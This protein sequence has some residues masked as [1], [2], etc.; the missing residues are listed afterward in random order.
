MIRRQDILPL[1]LYYLGVSRVRN[2]FIRLQGRSVTRI[3]TFHDI[4]PEAFDNFQTNINFLKQKTNVIGFQ[5]YFE[6][7]L[8]KKKINVIITFDDG[9]KS[10]LTY[11]VPA[12]K[13]LGLP[14][15]FFVTTGFVGLSKEAESE[16]I[17]SKL[18]VTTSLL[19]ISGGLSDNEVKRIAEQGFTLG[20]HTLSHCNLGK[21]Q[22]LGTLKYEIAG[23]KL[24][25]ERISRASIEYFAYPSGAYDNPTID[26][27]KVLE[28]LGFRGAV[29]TVPGFN[30]K[31]ANPY[32]LRRDLTRDYMPAPVFRAIVY[33]SHDMALT[34]RKLFRRLFHLS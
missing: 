21:Y 6:G 31:N 3:T 27:V 29:T 5:D 9:Y 33:G 20:G 8:S 28:E 14:A 25:L 34:I 22:D 32:L 2:F 24:R 17:R 19:R 7:R 16:F 18:L 12:L 13:T 26:L 4:Q 30:N 10:W 15:T 23:D 1:F 11:A